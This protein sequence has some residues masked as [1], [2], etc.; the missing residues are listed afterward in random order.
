MMPGKFSLQLESICRR[1]TFHA[2]I[3]QRGFLGR[4]LEL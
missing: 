1:I 3:G 4:F 2:L